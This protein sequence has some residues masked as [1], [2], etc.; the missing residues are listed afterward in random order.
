[1]KLNL[2]ICVIEAPYLSPR[3]AQ[4]FFERQ[5]GKDEKA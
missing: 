4:N 3:T 2:H 1:L 5:R